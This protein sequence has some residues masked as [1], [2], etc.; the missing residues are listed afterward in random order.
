MAP[1]FLTCIVAYKMWP[2]SQGHQ[3]PLNCY[4]WRHMK[5]FI[6]ER[7]LKL[8]ADLTG[9]IFNA[10]AGSRN[11]CTIFAQQLILF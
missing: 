5:I 1:P 9:C 11:N 3:I 6:Y 8:V 7:K 10:M 4:L 2:T